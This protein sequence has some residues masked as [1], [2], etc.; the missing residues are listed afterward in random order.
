M[1]SAIA[2]C[3]ACA[4]LGYNFEDACLLLGCSKS[5]TTFCEII[6][7]TTDA[8]LQHSAIFCLGNIL[9]ISDDEF[10]EEAVVS[11]THWNATIMAFG[12]VPK[13]AAIASTY[14]G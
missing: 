6:N 9:H 12:I 7:N 11:R 13:L 1:A 14:K 8:T 4:T 5:L 2:A 10:S 3:N